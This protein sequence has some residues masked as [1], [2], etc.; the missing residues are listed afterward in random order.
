MKGTE[1]V[2]QTFRAHLIVRQAGKCVLDTYHGT[3]TPTPKRRPHPVYG[4]L[5]ARVRIRRPRDTPN[6]K[7]VITWC[8]VN[9]STGRE[10]SHD[11][12]QTTIG[13]ANADAHAMA[14]AAQTAWFNNWSRSDLKQKG[15]KHGR[16]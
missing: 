3:V 11:S 16:I 8:I 14:T 1:F 7:P 9:H 2:D 13:R 4:H 15:Y 6:G 10:F 5:R 12:T